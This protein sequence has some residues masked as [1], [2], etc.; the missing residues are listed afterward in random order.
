MSEGVLG[1]PIIE[2]AGDPNQ[3]AKL[4]H[5]AR[6]GRAKPALPGLEIAFAAGCGGVKRFLRTVNFTGDS[7]VGRL[8]PTIASYRLALECRLQG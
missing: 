8:P 6:A 7:I 1:K 2:I 3:V 5:E 4:I